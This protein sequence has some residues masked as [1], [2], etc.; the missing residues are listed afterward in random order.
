MNCAET[1]ADL[2]QYRLELI[3]PEETLTRREAETVVLYSVS[4]SAPIVK[5][6]CEWRV[7]NAGHAWTASSCDVKGVE[8]QL[9][10][11]EPFC[12]GLRVFKQ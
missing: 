11:E 4:K 8:C 12:L 6:L 9:A 1:S 2:K 7:G 10:S 3:S 5:P